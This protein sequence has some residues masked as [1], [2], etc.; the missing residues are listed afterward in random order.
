MFFCFL[1]RWDLGTL[2]LLSRGLCAQKPVSVSF[3]RTLAPFTLV[4]FP[5]HLIK[6]TSETVTRTSSAVHFKADTRGSPWSFGSFTAHVSA[7]HD[8]SSWNHFFPAVG[9]TGEQHI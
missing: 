2:D 9:G 7:S 4:H 8:L 5:S 6:K 3:L 1:L